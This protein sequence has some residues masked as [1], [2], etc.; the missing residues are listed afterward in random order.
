[1]KKHMIA[2]AVAA[3]AVAVQAASFNWTA[4]GLA[5][6]K[7]IYA[8]DGST[9]LATA[10]SSAVLYLF[11]AA[12][13]SQDALLAALRGGKTIDGL[14]SVANQAIASNSRITAQAVTYGTAGKEYN[15]Y[16]AVINGDDVF[17]SASSSS[18]G[19]ASDTSLIAINGMSTATKNVFGDAAYSS[20]GWYS[21]AAVPEPTSGVLL[22]LGMAGL[23]LKRKRS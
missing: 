18:S 11:D 2:I 22:L 3:C 1:M 19:Q 15:F 17:I 16:M 5:S 23:A 4:S 12:T 10:N 13:V 8:K 14:T 7:N 21:T 9:L 20:A 6:T